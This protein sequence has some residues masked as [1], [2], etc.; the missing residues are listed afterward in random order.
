[1]QMADHPPA[2]AQPFLQTLQRIDHLTP[3]QGTILIQG[4][5]QLHFQG[6][7]LLLELVEQLG[8]VLGHLIGADRLEAGQSRPRQQGW[9]RH[10]G[11]GHR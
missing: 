7:Q 10:G 11:A 4:A 1:M 8:N 5:L 9:R 2:P 3:G 6:G